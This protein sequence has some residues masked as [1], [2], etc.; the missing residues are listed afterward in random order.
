MLLSLILYLAF[1]VIIF[2][3]LIRILLFGR[4]VFAVFLAL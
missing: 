4:S 2:L 1:L 3:L